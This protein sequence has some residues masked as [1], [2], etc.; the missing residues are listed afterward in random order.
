MSVC[1]QTVKVVVMNKDSP[2]PSPAVLKIASV[3]ER[4]ALLLKCL[5]QIVYHEVVYF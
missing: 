1:E 3:C 4:I 5:I 2:L